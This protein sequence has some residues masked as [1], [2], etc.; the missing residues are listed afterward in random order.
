MLSLKQI[1]PEGAVEDGGQESVDLGGGFGLKRLQ[2]VHLGELPLVYRR[3]IGRA[4]TSFKNLARWRRRARP[5]A[6]TSAHLAGIYH[7]LAMDNGV[8]APLAM[9]VGFCGYLCINV[10]SRRTDV[11]LA[12]HG[13]MARGARQP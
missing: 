7:K 11:W 9:E 4:K 13:C 10:G 5:S 8:P 12:A 3:Q 1:T 6:I 2:P